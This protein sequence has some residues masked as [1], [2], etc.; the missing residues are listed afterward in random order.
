MTTFQFFQIPDGL[1]ST[2]SPATATT[3]WKAVGTDDWTYV[4]VYALSAT[5]AVV[6]TIYGTLYRQDIR[7]NKVAY[8]QFMVSVPYGTRQN[9]SGEWTWDFDTTGGSVHI[10]NAK[11]EIRRYPSATAP[12][13]KGAI[14]VDAD[15]V[16]GV[17]IVIPSM[18]INVT[19]R[20]PQ[21]VITLSQAKFLSSITGT[22]N[23]AG[24]LS[25]APGE[26]LF[27]GARGSD[28]SVA[29][30]NVTYQFDVSPNLQNATIGTIE[31]VRKDGHEVLWI[32][33]N[34]STETVGGVTLPVRTPKFI[35]VDRVYEQTNLGIALGFGT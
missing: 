11:E 4:N 1:E 35:Y 25:F 15:Q 16:Q 6:A 18:R 29:E 34:D 27:L 9:A 33:Y 23:N 13:Q 22:V 19:Y 5:P 20:H 17:D 30:A 3:K 26:V 14:S 7:V 8:N 24:F 21:G 12:N 31:G 10:T 2:A 32:K 28:G